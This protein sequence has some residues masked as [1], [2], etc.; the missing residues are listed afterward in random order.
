M[1]GKF[2]LRYV[3]QK[4]FLLLLVNVIL[5]IVFEILGL[6]YSG[7]SLIFFISLI[8]IF[9]FAMIF[10]IDFSDFDFGN[11]KTLKSGVF[12][13][14][15]IM[16]FSIIFRDLIKSFSILYGVM[17][18]WFITT[19]LEKSKKTTNN[20]WWESVYENEFDEDKINIFWRVNTKFEPKYKGNIERIRFNE[21]L[22]FGVI[23]WILLFSTL[24][25]GDIGGRSVSSI[26]IVG[27][28][29]IY[30]FIKAKLSYCI[31]K[32]LNTHVE[33][34]GICTGIIEKR[35]SRNGP[36]TY[37]VSIVDFEN[38]IERIL[39]VNEGN[40]FMFSEGGEVT[41]VYGAISKKVVMVY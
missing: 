40:I 38:K 22:D 19:I 11:I 14:I 27:I 35:S 20:R 24:S 7:S 10:K 5:A 28:M 16:V 34:N 37:K 8:F 12:M 4:L 32:T 18:A 1:R 26:F 41:L 9:E 33:I 29:V 2:H 17:I 13:G 25:R 23:F 31:D 36:L 6:K 30:I 21:N 3:K 15:L 39:N